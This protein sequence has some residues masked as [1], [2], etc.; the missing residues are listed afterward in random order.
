[1]PLPPA[2]PRSRACWWR[3]RPASRPGPPRSSCVRQLGVGRREDVGRARPGGSARRARRSRRRTASTSIAGE[4]V[5]VVRERRLSEEA[6]ETISCSPPRAGPSI[7]QL[8]QPPRPRPRGQTRAPRA[9]AGSTRFT[10]RRARPS[11]RSPSPVAV[12]STPRRRP[13]LLD[14]VARDRRGDAVRAG[15]D[16]DQRHHAVDL[17]RADDA[18]EAVAGRERV[19]GRRGAPARRAA[20]RP[21]APGRGGGC[22]RRGSSRSLPARSQRRSVSTLTPSARAASPRSIEVRHLPK[23]C[24]GRCTYALRRPRPPAPSRAPPGRARRS[25]WRGSSSRRRCRGCARASRTPRSPGSS[26]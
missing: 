13:E 14:R 24:I 6:A 18:G 17:D 1:M 15:L 16:L 3:R 12:A 25:P 9:T 7:A 11:P 21:P 5:G 23:H 4:L 10:S 22:A 20:A 2:A 19:A 8:P 26:R